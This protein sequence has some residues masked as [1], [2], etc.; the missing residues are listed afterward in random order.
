[1]KNVLET[2]RDSANSAAKTLSTKQPCRR[3]PL[4]QQLVIRIMQ[5]VMDDIPDTRMCEGSAAGLRMFSKV[6]L[7]SAFQAHCVPH[8]VAPK[9]KCFPFS[10]ALTNLNFATS[11]CLNWTAV[12][13]D[14][15]NVLF[16]CF[17]Y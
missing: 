8:P 3:G 17:S 9:C 16:Y 4:H 5:M 14:K 1:V 11:K 10:T 2:N 7:D 6:I 15:P 12:G 13:T